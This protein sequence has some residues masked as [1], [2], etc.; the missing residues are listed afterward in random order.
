MSQKKSNGKK[1]TDKYKKEKSVETNILK[2]VQLS[3]E[4][5]S[6][7]L[8]QTSAKLPSLV[9]TRG[10][11]ID[12]MNGLLQEKF[13]TDSEI[14]T[15]LE[16]FFTRLVLLLRYRANYDEKLNQISKQIRRLKETE[17]MGE[18]KGN[19][20][21]LGI[22]LQETEQ[23]V[24]N[25][26]NMYSNLFTEQALLQFQLMEQLSMFRERDV[27]DFSEMFSL[28]IQTFFKINKKISNL[29]E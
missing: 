23:I 1:S 16:E 6:T 11:I 20:Q 4:S 26:E 29:K 2:E 19:L 25:Y 18:F 12:D 21:L 28:S 14:I 7:I 8:K 13:K 9:S 10:V 27:P 3:L 24:K 22:T 5:I 15:M 17:K